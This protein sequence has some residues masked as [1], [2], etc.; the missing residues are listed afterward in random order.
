[1][2]QWSSKWDSESP[3]GLWVGSILFPRKFYYFY[4][5]KFLSF[6]QHMI[7]QIPANRGLWSDLWQDFEAFSFSAALV[8]WGNAVQQQVM[9]RWH[10]QNVI[11]QKIKT[12][13]WRQTSKSE[14][15]LARCSLRKHSLPNNCQLSKITESVLHISCLHL[16]IVF[17]FFLS[18]AKPSLPFLGLH[19]QPDYTIR[20]VTV[21]ALFILLV[22][23]TL[24]LPT[25]TTTHYYFSQTKKPQKGSSL[26][27]R[28][29]KPSFT[30]ILKIS[31][32]LCGR[33][34]TMLLC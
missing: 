13:T 11:P 19:L 27:L 2:K 14:E 1:M 18:L 34:S 5:F 33:V 29:R 10:T 12:I 17:F 23:L 7:N 32:F 24:K 21:Y 4:F 30:L 31:D 16:H 9:Q 22:W 25:R 26:I 20:S 6:G 28:G 3:R 8:G 15:K